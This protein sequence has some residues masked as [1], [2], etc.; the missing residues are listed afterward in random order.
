LNRT[1]APIGGPAGIL[2]AAGVNITVNVYGNDPDKVV[3]AIRKYGRRNGAM[4]SR[5]LDL[6]V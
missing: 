4:N 1:P 2:G 3:A 5:I 6:G